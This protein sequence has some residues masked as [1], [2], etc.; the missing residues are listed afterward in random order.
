MNKLV[1]TFL[2]IF[3]SSSMQ[4]QKDSLQLGD[5]Y[6]EDQMYI[7]ISYA[8]LFSQPEAISRSSFSYGISLGILKDFSLNKDGTFALAMGI[9]YG[10][11]FF[12]HELKVE[13]I[14]GTTIFNEGLNITNNV[15][16]GHN[17]EFPIEV[18]WRTSNAKK[19]NFWRI[20][21]GIKF[22][23]NLSNKFQ[24]DENGTS[25]QFKNVS[26][27]NNFRYGLTLSAGFDEFNINIFYSLNP[28]FENV[29]FN[30]QNI[31]SKILKFGLIFYIL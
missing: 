31:N 4:A 19:Y 16:K 28:I 10:Y 30:N 27:Y 15:F 26:A 21:G 13:E 6:S 24:F 3:L 2:I 25:F 5:R 20:Y 29:T 11:D 9:G 1:Y 14:N 23:Y 7:S 17:L 18:R 22:L 8:Q 12:N